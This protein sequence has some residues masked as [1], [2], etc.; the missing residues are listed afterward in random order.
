MPGKI[1]DLT[2]MNGTATID[3]AADFLEITDTSGG[4]SYKVT[5]NFLLGITSAP[6]GTTDSQS[7]TNKTFDNSNTITARDDRFTLQDNSD[8]TK[9]AK[10][11]LSG[12][13]TATTRTYTLPDASSTLVDLSSAQT[14]TNKTLTSPTINTPTITNPTL[15]I[16]SI[17]E[18]TAA[19]GV[20]IDGLLIKDGLLPAGNIQ[21][22]N[23]QSGTGSSWAWQT[24]APTLTNL[25]GGTINYAKYIQIGKT[26]FLRFKYTLAGAGVSGAPRFTLPVSAS[27]NYAAGDYGL[28]AGLLFDATGN[29]FFPIANF[30]S[31]GAMD[32]AHVNANSNVSAISSTAPFT[33]ATGD[34]ILVSVVYEAA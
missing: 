14:L 8:T 26:V 10:F 4:V 1:S 29:A 24:W 6:L 7:P 17:S 23:L 19:N 28:V 25:S 5:P 22:L 13:T 11:E 18:Y 32:I 30:A 9:Q 2:N 21:P 20:T 33:W 15:T 16:N 34:H 3:R 12:I 27:S 31:A